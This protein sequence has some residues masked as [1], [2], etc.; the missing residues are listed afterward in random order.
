M[1]VDETKIGKVTHYYTKIG[2]AIIELTDT[3][4][5]GETIHIQGATTDFEQP[6]ESMQIEHESI[7]EAKAGDVIGLKIKEKVREGDIVSRK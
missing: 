2:V 3:L 6:V 4:K 1:K 7:D 5:V